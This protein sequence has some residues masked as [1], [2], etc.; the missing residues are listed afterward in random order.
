MGE[1]ITNTGH[2][3]QY[4]CCISIILMHFMRSCE[5]GKLQCICILVLSFSEDE[6]LEKVGTNFIKMTVLTA[7]NIEWYYFFQNSL[8][9]LLFNLD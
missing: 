1:G 8:I 7:Q 2:K 5:I 4:I 6:K 9:Y 3:N